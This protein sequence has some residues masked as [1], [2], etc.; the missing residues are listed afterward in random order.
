MRISRACYLSKSKSTA[1]ALDDLRLIKISLHVI[2]V[3]E[4]MIL[5][6]LEQ[7]NSAIIQSG[8]Y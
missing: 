1:A 5:A 2:K 8:Y 6:K 4:H 3:L 7:F